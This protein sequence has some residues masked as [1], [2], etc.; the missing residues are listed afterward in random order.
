MKDTVEQMTL[1]FFQ[2]C[3]V[4]EGVSVTFD[5]GIDL[6]DD[7]VGR[8]RYERLYSVRSNY[9]RGKSLSSSK[10]FARAQSSGVPLK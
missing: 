1:D 4:P 3:D 7:V 2:N 6:N 10:T 8:S 9:G 5:Q